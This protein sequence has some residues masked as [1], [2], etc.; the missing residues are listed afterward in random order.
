MTASDTAPSLHSWGHEGG[1]KSQRN[2]EN[3]LRRPRWVCSLWA[4][5]CTAGLQSSQRPSER[6]RLCAPRK[7][8]ECVT[9]DTLGC[10][11]CKTDSEWLTPEGSVSS[12]YHML[13][14]EGGF[15]ERHDQSAGSTS[16]PFPWFALVF[17]VARGLLSAAGTA[18][19]DLGSQRVGQEML[20][21][22]EVPSAPVPWGRVPLRAIFLFT[23]SGFR[24]L[25]GGLQEAVQRNANGSQVG[26]SEE[27]PRGLGSSRLG[28][29]LGDTAMRTCDWGLQQFWGKK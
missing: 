8:I 25:K 29:M 28:L 7:K 19:P 13:R 15:Q 24:M 1:K 2:G 21:V 27:P 3:R 4:G 9:W 6:D 20:Q 5:I 22:A 14:R 12:H 23:S 16:L 11:S 26:Q 18:L 17:M 10:M